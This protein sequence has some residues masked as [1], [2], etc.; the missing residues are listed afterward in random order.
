VPVASEPAPSP[1][2]VPN[3]VAP[4]DATL[5]LTADPAAIV[6]IEGTGFS[7]TTPT[8]VRALSLRPGSYRVSFRSETYASPVTTQV[9]LAS[10]TKRNV[11]ADFRAAV[12]TVT[13]R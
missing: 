10:G 11:H 2:A 1:A 5:R 6:S 12:P 9:T 3:E 8:P 4:A 7:Q 13:V